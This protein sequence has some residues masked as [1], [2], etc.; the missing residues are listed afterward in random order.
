MT[1]QQKQEIYNKW[2]EYQ[3]KNNFPVPQYS[4][5]AYTENAYKLWESMMTK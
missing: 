5:K 4:Y 1:E 2:Y 3:R